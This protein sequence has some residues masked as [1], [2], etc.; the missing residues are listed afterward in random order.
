VR[1]FVFFLLLVLLSVGCDSGG[2]ALDPMNDSITG[3]WRGTVP[4]RNVQGI[5][6][7]F[8]V[9]M[10]IRQEQFDLSGTG[11]ITGPAGGQPFTIVEGSSY[12]HP[13]LSIQLL[14]D[15]PPLG[16]LKGNVAED[17]M[18]I[19]G[20]M[21]GPGFSGVAELEIEMQRV[22]PLPGAVP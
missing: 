10:Q 14:Y 6:D 9:E 17:R 1:H 5:V 19:R 15:R 8:R 11:T 22:A 18:H 4:S 2:P 3:V 12:L 20:T 7:T 13:I 16:D 21:S